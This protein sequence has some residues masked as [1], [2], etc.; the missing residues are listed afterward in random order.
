MNVRHGIC[1][2]ALSTTRTGAVT[3]PALAYGAS[4][5]SVSLVEVIPTSKRLLTAEES[6][7]RLQ[8]R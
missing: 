1:Q 3:L 8:V 7:N 2:T 4:S 6:S 5:S